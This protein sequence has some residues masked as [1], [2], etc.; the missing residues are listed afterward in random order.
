VHKDLQLEVFLSFKDE[1]VGKKIAY[2]NPVKLDEEQQQVLKVWNPLW[3][4]M[5]GKARDPND[6]SSE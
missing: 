5:G 3:E 2:Q 6:E 4:G 1:I